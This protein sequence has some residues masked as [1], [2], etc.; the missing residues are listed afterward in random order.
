[1]QINSLSFQFS[2]LALLGILIFFIPLYNLLRPMSLV[3]KFMW[4]TMVMSVAAQAFLI[5]LLIHYFN[6]VSI[7]SLLSSLVAIPASY[8]IL[9]SGIFLLLLHFLL[10][11]VA[12]LLGHGIDIGI[13]LVNEMIIAMSE[14]PM[15]YLPDVY[16]PPIEVAIL[17]ATTVLI[18]LRILTLNKKCTYAA[19]LGVVLFGI[20]HTLSLQQSIHEE[21]LAIYPSDETLA[22][23]F[24]S[25]GNCF[26]T[27]NADSMPPFRKK[28]IASFRNTSRA[29]KTQ[30]AL[31]SSVTSNNVHVLELSG[32][33]SESSCLRVA[34]ITHSERGQLD[35]DLLA[36]QADWII[37]SSGL[38]FRIRR[39]A[40]D[41]CNQHRIQFHDLREHGTFYLAK[42]KNNNSN[43][44]QWQNISG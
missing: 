44:T 24:I 3:G 38:T 33:G 21:M 43:E 1:L 15:S 26:T 32:H 41:F 25:E 27:F 8:G 6:Q 5:P 13:G 11:M 31:S 34:V 9:I 16:L 35:S 39:A 20:L 42:H 28:E 2:Y 36:L 4:A 22:I 23:D 17:C 18:A 7:I 12:N 40:Q 19:M 37:L 14:F 10:P 30:Q 29:Q